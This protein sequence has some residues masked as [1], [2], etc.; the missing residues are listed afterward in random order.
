M[1]FEHPGEGALDYEPCRYGESKQLFRGPQ[2]RLDSP[3]VAFLGSTETYGRFIET[4]FPE[5]IEQAT[6]H[7]TVNL[8]CVNAGVDMFVHDPSLIEIASKAEVSVIQVMGAQNMSNRFYTVH[9]RRNDRFIKPS[10]F[11]RDAFPEVDFTEFAFTRHLLASLLRQ[12]P[13]QFDLVVEELKTA[14]LAR[15]KMMIEQIGGRIVLLWMA[16]TPPARDARRLSDDLSEPAFIDRR[17]I[18]ELAPLV[19]DVVQAVS[20]PRARAV[21]TAGMV[22]SDL[23]APIAG[24]TP[25]V[26]AHEEATEALAPTISGLMN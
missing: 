25:G 13:D 1:A 14:W 24:E 12:C 19:D 5:L 15:M 8:G 4:P 7:R 26:I 17:M 9:P 18:E 6:G 10:R 20:S 3:F 11:M 21:G 22:F 16:N 2:K 23:E